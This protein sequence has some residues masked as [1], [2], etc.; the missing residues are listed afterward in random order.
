MAN[1]FRGLRAAAAGE[2]FVGNGGHV[3]LNVDTIHQRSGN[4]RHVSLD[5][6]R[7]AETLA[8][9]VIGKTARTEVHR[10]DQEERRGKRERHLPRAIVTRRSS[11]G[12]LST[13]R[14]FRGNSGSSSR[15][16]TP[17][18]DMLTSPGRG[19]EPPPTRPASDIV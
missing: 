19:M 2:I 15:N 13:S 9:E 17:L 10:R 4:F 3:H 8:A 16:K 14:M 12:C 5:L 6:R 1:G 7:C 18:W 11:R